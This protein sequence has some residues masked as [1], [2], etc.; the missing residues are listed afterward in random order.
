MAVLS[1]KNHYERAFESWLR[2][3][4]IQYISVDQNK[5]IVFRKTSVKS[6][7]FIISSKNRQMLIV[8]VKGRKFK[9]NSLKKISALQTWVN[10]DDVE[11]LENW[12]KIFGNNYKAVFAFVYKIEL[13]EVDFGHYDYFVFDDNKYIFLIIS[14]DEYKKRMVLRSPKWRT[15][16]LLT[17]DVKQCALTANEFLN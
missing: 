3:R 10:M 2:E 4:K 6:F 12:Q 1:T 9:A 5:R 13:P 15:V 8:E 17:K 11:G 16:T 14:L 7:D